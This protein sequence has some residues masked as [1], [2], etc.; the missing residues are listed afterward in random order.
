MKIAPPPDPNESRSP[1][2]ARVTSAGSGGIATLL[3]DGDETLLRFEPL[4]ASKRKLSREDGALQYGRVLDEKLRVVDDVVVSVVDFSKSWTGNTQIEVSCH[5]GVGTLAALEALLLEAGFRPARGTELL[6]RAHLNGKLS[7]LALESRVRL[8]AAVTA[9]QADFL[10]A[11]RALQEKWE[12]LGF[13]MALGLREKRDDWR[14]KIISAADEAI[15][16]SAYALNLLRPHTIA[17]VGPVN[18]GKSTLANLLARAD[19]HIVSAQPGTTR[20]KLDTALDIRGMNVILSDTAGL[21]H[22]ADDAVEAEGQ[23]RAL[24]AAKSAELRLVVLDGS[25]PPDDAHVE[26]LKTMLAHGPT[27]LILN[28]KDLGLD[29]TAAGLGFLIGRDPIAISAQT[30]EGLDT[31]ESQLEAQLLGAKT[32][33]DTTAFTSRQVQR[34]T[35]LREGLAQNH[36]GMDEMIHLRK[37]IG[38]R[39]DREELR[40]AIADFGL[41]IAD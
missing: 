18:A 41:R 6:E 12:R 1:V 25:C 22:A 35:T 8:A 20:D 38:S 15:A 5:G 13:D 9:R 2:F 7:L 31:L 32:P 29:E 16:N 40:T 27:L 10:L 33:G 36:H 37:F 34:L 24:E 23:R 4:F 39:P 14:A 11:T 26:L 28:K 30:G 21:R 17:I 19:R 3:L